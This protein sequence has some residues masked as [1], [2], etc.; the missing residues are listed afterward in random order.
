M[1]QSPIHSRISDSNY[2]MGQSPIHSRISDS[3]NIIRVVILLEYAI[4]Y[5]T[6][7]Y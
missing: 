1:G 7:D 6:T 5:I 3:N 4:K 2:E